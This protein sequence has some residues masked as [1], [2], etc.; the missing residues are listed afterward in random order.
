MAQIGTQ[1]QHVPVDAVLVGFD[2]GLEG[3]GGEAVTE[4][5][6]PGA[7]L[8]ALTAK[9]NLSSQLDQRYDREGRAP[10]GRENEQVVVPPIS[11]NL[12]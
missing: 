7:G 4:I 1:R 12:F 6:K 5:V 10:A 9:P 11:V 3:S 2:D 8:T